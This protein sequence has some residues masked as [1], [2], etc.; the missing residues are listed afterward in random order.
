M[1]RIDNASAWYGQIQ[2]LHGVSLQVEQHEIVTL[3]GANGA[4]KLDFD[5]VGVRATSVTQWPY[6]VRGAGLDRCAIPQGIELWHYLGALSGTRRVFPQMTVWENLLTGAMHRRD[7]G[8]THDIERV[9]AI[10]PVLKET[11][12][13]AGRHVVGGRAADAGDWA[14]A[15]GSDRSYC[16]SMSRRLV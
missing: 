4:G 8:I 10:F 11:P 14:R 7:D 6:R 12:R 2:A 9:Y 5:D 16:C 13:A 15:N 3:I 1:L